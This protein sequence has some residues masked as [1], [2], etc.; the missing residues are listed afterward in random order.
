MRINFSIIKTLPFIR[1]NNTFLVP[2]LSDYDELKKHGISIFF[3][4][5]IP[6]TK[7]NF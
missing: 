3:R 1:S 4:P 7:K 6:L 5:K 2:F